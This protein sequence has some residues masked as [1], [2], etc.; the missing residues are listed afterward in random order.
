VIEAV[1]YVLV[2]LGLVAG[3]I[4]FARKPGFWIE[5]GWRTFTALR[6]FIVAY[7]TK[8]MT[9]EKE[10]EFQDCVRRGGEWDFHRKRCKR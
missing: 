3:A 9:P 4:L 2:G 10:K 8:R 5:L 6:P 1:A 7:V